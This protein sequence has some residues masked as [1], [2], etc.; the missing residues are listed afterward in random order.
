MMITM[1]EPL[2]LTQM[3]PPDHFIAHKLFITLSLLT[4]GF[5]CNVIYLLVCKA[6][7]NYACETFCWHP[8]LGLQEILSGSI[9]EHRW[10]MNI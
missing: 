2:I 6:S 10:D 4:F 7:E 5:V 9:R 3:H 8:T 1:D